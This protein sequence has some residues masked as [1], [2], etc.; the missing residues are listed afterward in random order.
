M[1]E[2]SEA[3]RAKELRKEQKR[4]KKKKRKENKCKYQTDTDTRPSIEECEEKECIKEIECKEEAD[5]KKE[6]EIETDEKPNETECEKENIVEE[7]SPKPNDSCSQ[8]LSEL[9]NGCQESSDESSSCLSEKGN[10]SE[11]SSPREIAEN[12]KCGDEAKQK[13]GYRK[14]GYIR[15]YEEK[16]YHHSQGPARK[17]KSYVQQQNGFIAAILCRLCGQPICARGKYRDGRSDWNG[18][19]NGMEICPKC[20]MNSGPPKRGRKKMGMGRPKEVC[21]GVFCICC[22]HF[23]SSHVN[24]NSLPNCNHINSRLQFCHQLQRPAMQW[25]QEIQGRSGD[26][27]PEI[28]MGLTITYFVDI[29]IVSFFF[30]ILYFL[31]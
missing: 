18:I 6:N 16:S 1:E 8:P 17:M 22:V 10:D 14:N 31:Y 7:T 2:I 12:C 15:S 13:G 3:E 25:F 27:G 30:L 26:H 23:L 28:Y 11:K 9:V 24:H 4:L 5:C 20:A 29:F 19:E 21:G